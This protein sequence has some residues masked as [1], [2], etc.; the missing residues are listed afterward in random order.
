MDYVNNIVHLKGKKMHDKN[1]KRH[2]TK[3]MKL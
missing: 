3:N 2:T 1:A